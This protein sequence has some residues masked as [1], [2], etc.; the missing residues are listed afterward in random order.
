MSQ[1]APGSGLPNLESTLSSP[2]H[3]HRAAILGFTLATILVGALIALGIVV[4]GGPPAF[5][6]A[7][8][9]AL[10]A[11]RDGPVGGI[12][13]MLSGIGSLVVWEAS[14]RCWRVPSGSGG[15]ASAR[16]A[17][18]SVA[19]R[20]DRALSDLVG[21]LSTRSEE[22]RIL[23]AGHDVRFH[24]TGEKSFHH[25]LSGGPGPRLRPVLGRARIAVRGR[26][27]RARPLG[28][29][30]GRAD[31]RSRRRL[32]RRFRPLTGGR[33]HDA[34]DPHYVRPSLFGGTRRR[35]AGLVIADR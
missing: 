18:R 30:E 29:E 15:S 5:D 33:E 10:R 9:G 34:S 35:T 17:W 32:S 3:V 4:R 14:W 23:W 13:G 12:L 21:R 24:R 2:G 7:T 6:V 19:T 22:F 11:S 31:V 26:T 20:F 16:S 8:I 1:P 28:R 25:P 27:G